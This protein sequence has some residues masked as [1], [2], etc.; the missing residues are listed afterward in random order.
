[1][2]WRGL[3][4]LFGLLF[5]ALLLWEGALWVQILWWKNH[6]PG[7]TAFMEISFERRMKAGLGPLY[8]HPWTPW[9][10]IPHSLKQAVV[11]AED[12][13]FVS[14]HGFDFEG[15]KVA[16]QKDVKRGKWVAGGST[17]SQQLAKNLFLSGHRSLLRKVQEALITGMIEATW[18]KR[19][20]LEVYLNVIEWGDGIYGCEAA[21]R[22]YYGKPVT[23]LQAPE[24]ADLAV[25][26]P[27]PR[28]FENHEETEKFQEKREVIL[29]R[30]NRVSI[31][32]E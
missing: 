31:P 1:M 12:S 27:S 16:A 7:E 4:I 13:T 24:A 5:L 30:M 26:I 23:A 32:R 17:I 21:A 3:K 25:R 14:H 20:I 9:S 6:N 15:M 10:S 22:H 18:S 19:R 29:D 11:A 2:V 28:W 8:P